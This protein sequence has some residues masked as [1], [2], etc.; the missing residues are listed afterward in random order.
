MK[1]IIPDNRHNSSI[2]KNLRE[3]AKADART[4]GQSQ[5]SREIRNATVISDFS[6]LLTINNLGS[7]CFLTVN[8]FYP[9]YG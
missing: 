6:T 3:K 7:K 9:N 4:Y 5:S 8:Y 2:K 1:K